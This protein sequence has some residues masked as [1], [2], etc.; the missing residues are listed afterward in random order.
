MCGAQLAL[1]FVNDSD[2]FRAMKHGPFINLVSDT[3]GLESKSVAVI[4]RAIR[5][6][7]F[8]TSGARGVNAPHMTPLDAAR[9]CI[10]L[11]T[12]ETPA[13]ILPAFHHYRSLQT[14]TKTC[15][16]LQDIGVKQGHLIEVALSELFAAFEDESVFD[17]YLLEFD[18]R[19]P[20]LPPISVTLCENFQHIKLGAPDYDATYRDM[21]YHEKWRLLNN[22]TEAMI[23]SDDNSLINKHFNK[24]EEL[25]ARQPA[26][27]GM[28]VSREITIVEIKKIGSGLCVA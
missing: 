17:P 7:G 6:D 21:N 14:E 26:H 12:G 24:L 16:L 15:E 19:G 3:F 25:N 27:K 22:R 18:Q 8:L 5:E 1:T 11:M 2:T 10:A 9:I 23:K 20:M 13:K 4:V 28:R